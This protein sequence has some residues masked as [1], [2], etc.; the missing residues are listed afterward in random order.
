MNEMMLLAQQATSKGW[1]EAYSDVI[2]SDYAD[3]IGLEEE[4]RSCLTWQVECVP[5]LLQ[6]ED[7]AREINGWFQ[8]MV[9]M[10]P[11]SMERRVQVRMLRQRVLTRDPPLELSVVLEESALLR[12]V[13]DQHVMRAQ[14]ERLLEAAEMVNIRIRVLPLHGK[15]PIMAGSF[16]LLT[17]GEDHEAAFH[18]VVSTENLLQ[19][20]AFDGETD[21]YLYRR[22]FDHMMESSLSA[23]DSK[24]LIADT[25]KRV[26]R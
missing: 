6:T 1:W 15:R 26:W 9:A 4:A 25:A 18:D 11:A 12:Q 7:Y 21:T 17:F 23:A 20:L 5:G 2:S 8:R 10:P 13:A 19:S 3:L 22:T 16:A 24:E 14:L